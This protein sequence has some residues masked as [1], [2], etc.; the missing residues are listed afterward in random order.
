MSSRYFASRMKQPAATYWPE[1]EGQ[2]K[3]HAD[4]AYTQ[5]TFRK[6]YCTPRV[7]HYRVVNPAS[8]YQSDLG[9]GTAIEI[10][11]YHSWNT[12]LG[13]LPKV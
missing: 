7:K 3:M 4:S 13:N 8:L 9:I 6:S 2:F 11:K 1:Q 10:I 5:V 12:V